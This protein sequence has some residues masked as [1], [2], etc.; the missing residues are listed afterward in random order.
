MSLEFVG[1]GR[2]TSHSIGLSQFYY[3]LKARL[4]LLSSGHQSSRRGYHKERL[5]EGVSV[6]DWPWEVFHGTREGERTTQTEAKAEQSSGGM[7]D[8]CWLQ[9]VFSGLSVERVLGEWARRQLRSLGH[10]KPWKTGCQLYRLFHY[11]VDIWEPT[12]FKILWFLWFLMVFIMDLFIRGVKHVIIPI[13]QIRKLRNSCWLKL[14]T[15][16]MVTRKKKHPL[17][18]S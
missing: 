16:G 14:F 9:L 10:R 6:S 1:G 17:Y 18:T 3:H 12:F 11:L 8:M 15:V 7:Q 13:S 5:C 4:L 2:T